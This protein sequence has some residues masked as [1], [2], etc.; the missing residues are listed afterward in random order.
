MPLLHRRHFRGVRVPPHF[1]EWG[2]HTPYFLRAVTRKITMQTQAF[3][4][5]QDT[6]FQIGATSARRYIQTPHLY[7]ARQLQQ[8]A[9][10]AWLCTS[11]VFVCRK[12][13]NVD[14]RKIFKIV[15]T[16]PVLFGSNMHQIA[17]RLGP[18]PRPYWGNL[19]RSP[20]P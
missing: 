6:N 10:A 2:Y 5:G 7:I 18:R 19:Q 15:A 17:C 9:T 12:Q 4:T 20:D 3:S 1:L 16:R 13:T 14:R 11:E 8:A